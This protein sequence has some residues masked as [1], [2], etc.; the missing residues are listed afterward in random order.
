MHISLAQREPLEPLMRALLTAASDAE[1]E[2]LREHLADCISL[3]LHSMLR[4]R[5]RVWG[6][7]EDV[8]DDLSQECC[9]AAWAGLDRLDHVEE[10]A[11][12]VWLSRIAR[13][14]VADYFRRLS[15]DRRSKRSE[16]HDEVTTPSRRAAKKEAY[17]FVVARM[18]LLP[19]RRRVALELAFFDGLGSA[20]IG[21]EL[22]LSR[23]AA[24]MT[25]K[26]GL[27]DLQARCT[28]LD[29]PR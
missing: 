9:L 20:E 6:L 14:K 5:L 19:Q 24:A 29:D 18:R 1:R 8:V 15:A 26:R 16:E 11:I 17:D 10:A 4:M 3:R 13:N 12:A 22:G 25:I 7:A 27:A 23:P 2:H 21:R 28:A